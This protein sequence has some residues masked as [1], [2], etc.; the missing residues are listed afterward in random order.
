MPARGGRINVHYLT[1]R[2]DAPPDRS[3]FLN[4]S[5]NFMQNEA[6]PAADAFI[7]AETIRTATAA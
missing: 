3:I 1:N 2:G 5:S 4:I 6:T 7:D